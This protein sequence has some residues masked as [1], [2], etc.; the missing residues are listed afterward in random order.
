MSRYFI[1]VMVLLSSGARARAETSYS[2]LLQRIQSTYLKNAAAYP[3]LIMDRDDIEWRLV[4]GS[5]TGAQDVKKR[6]AIIKQYI[7]EKAGVK[8]S[9]NAASNFEPYI[10]V[11]KDS[12]SA[13]PALNDGTWSRGVAM[14]AVFPPDPNRNKR[15]ETERLLQLNM[16]EAYGTRNYNQLQATMEYD[17]YV[18]FSVLHES[19]HCMD[20][21]FFPSLY[22]GDDDPSTVHLTESY[23]E[24]VAVLLMAKEQRAEVAK[25]RAYLRDVYSY[26]MEPYFMSH[27]QNGMGN[28]SY[29]YAGLI[30]H[31]SPSIQGARSEIEARPDEIK[32]MSITALQDLAAQIVNKY[33]FDTRV[34]TAIFSSYS[35]GRIVALQRYQS[36]AGQY[37]DLFTEALNRLKTY[38]TDEDGFIASAFVT[39]RL[40]SKQEITQLKPV[41]FA[42]ICTLLKNGNYEGVLAQVEV[43]RQDL[44]SGNPS[45]EAELERFELLSGLWSTLPAKCLNSEMLQ[46]SGL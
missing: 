30:Y 41:D 10:T 4:Q 5:A 15:L 18:L 28:P 43:L 39:D 31:L 23:A 32:A 13:M 34:F 38:M 29:G 25:V 8:I 40:P 2:H 46:I 7:L 35:E 45:I 3:I 19:G 14:C 33:A 12:A 21:F 42:K 37:P 27:P 44:R 6:E 1:V 17:D 36:Y 26:F 20:R 22:N 9:D 11:L 16:K 24:T